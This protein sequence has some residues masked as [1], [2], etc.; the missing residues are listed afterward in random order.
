MPAPADKITTK[1]STKGQV[2]LPKAIRTRR[3]W[4]AG[5]TLVVEDTPDGVLL[6]PAPLFKPTRIEDV[7]GMLKYRG[8]PKTI[9]EMDAAIVA[10]VKR[11]H[12]RG[13][14]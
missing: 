11:R 9:A 8:K 13:R 5:T 14:Y 3:H 2:I 7:F 12:A 6:K 4:G 10:E 1:I